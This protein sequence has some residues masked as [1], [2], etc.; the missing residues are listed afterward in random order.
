MPEDIEPVIAEEPLCNQDTTNAIALLW[1]P[2]PFN[3]RSG[4]MRRCYDIALVSAWFKE[5]CPQGFPVKVR[6]SYQ[7]LLKT[8][9]LNSLHH[10]KPQTK[11]KRSLFKAF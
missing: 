1:A 6:V 11:K 8:W 5:Q 3:Q 9:V 4:K 7:K 2:S 10:K